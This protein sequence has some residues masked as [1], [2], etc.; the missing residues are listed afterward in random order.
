MTEVSILPS[1]DFD[2]ISQRKKALCCI[3]ENKK[4]MWHWMPSHLICKLHARGCMSARGWVSLSWAVS[5]YRTLFWLKTFRISA[6]SNH[7]TPMLRRLHNI[8]VT[9][10]AFEASNVT[11]HVNIEPEAENMT[12]P[13]RLG[14]GLTTFRFWRASRTNQSHCSTDFTAPNLQ[15]QQIGC[16]PGAKRRWCCGQVLKENTIFKNNEMFL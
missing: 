4:W 1:C 11:L 6:S 2:P 7:I 16:N 3:N 12:E 9:W 15:M 10:F 8:L 5:F 13:R 14:L